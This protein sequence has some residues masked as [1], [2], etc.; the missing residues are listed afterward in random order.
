MPNH[1]ADDPPYFTYGR[2]PITLFLGARPQSRRHHHWYQI[3]HHELQTTFG[4]TPAIRQAS[5]LLSRK[6]QDAVE[7]S[8][9]RPD[10]GQPYSPRS[11][12]NRHPSS[13]TSTR[14]VEPTEKVC[15][16]WRCAQET[17]WRFARSGQDLYESV[18]PSW[19][20]FEECDEI[21]RLVQDQGNLG[22]GPRLGTQ[23][24]PTSKQRSVRLIRL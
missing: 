6:R 18:R 22:Q 23:S 13:A 16:G 20:G 24:V 11:P 10:F 9:V 21:W 2:W 3:L 4:S 12:I 1:R 5:Q 14:P 8:A 19:R 7:A 17:V 15:V